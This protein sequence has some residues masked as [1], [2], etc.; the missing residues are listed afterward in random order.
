MPH[1]CSLPPH[2]PSSFHPLLYQ[3]TESSCSSL[4]KLQS[5]HTAVTLS[6]LSPSPPFHL[7]STFNASIHCQRLQIL[8]DATLYL[9]YTIVLLLLHRYF[10][11]PLNILSWVV[12]SV[13]IP[14]KGL[15]V[16][17]KCTLN[18][19][20]RK[21]RGYILKKPWGAV[22]LHRL[23]QWIDCSHRLSFINLT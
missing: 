17:A 20:W 14:T 1:S 21:G 2:L 18:R 19:A 10:W 16:C 6:S 5:P 15:N 13:M 4:C 23:L 22:W 12:F 3:C 8:F 9:M 7:H 11:S